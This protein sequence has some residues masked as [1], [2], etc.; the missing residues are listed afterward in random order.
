VTLQK[1]NDTIA[2]VINLQENL[3]GLEWFEVLLNHSEDEEECGK[4]DQLIFRF[5]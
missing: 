3:L 2:W 5:I 4:S 1:P